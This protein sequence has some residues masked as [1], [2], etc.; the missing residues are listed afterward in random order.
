MTAQTV[1]QVLQHHLQAFSENN[2]DEIMQDYSDES[3]ILVP[4]GKIAGRDGIRSFF[5]GAF[6]LFP[7]GKTKL[8][9]TQTIIEKDIVYISWVAESPVVSVPIGS[10]TFIIQNGIIIC[11]TAALYIIPK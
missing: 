9:L 8:E 5:A 6:Q 3:L 7:A 2:L 4:E 11:Q 10:D 1:Q